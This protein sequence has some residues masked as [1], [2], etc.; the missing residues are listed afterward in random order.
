M[1]DNSVSRSW[2]AVFDNPQDHGYEG[3]PEEVCERLKNEWISAS[4]TRCGAWCYCVSAKGLKHIHMV[5][6]D[7]KPMRFASI[8]KEYAVGMHFEATKGTRKQA[9]D[10]INKVPPFDEKG[11]EILY[12]TTHGE[13]RGRQGKRSDLDDYFDRLEAGETVKDI[14]RDTPRAYVHETVLKK[15]Y[16]DIRS[17]NTPIVRDMRVYWHTGLSGSGKSYERVKLCEEVGEENIFYLTSFNSGAFDNYNGEPYLWIEDYRGE[18]KLQELLRMLDCYKA[19][20]PARYSN[21][22]ALWNEVHITSVLTPREVYSKASLED[23]DRIDQLLRRITSIVYHF[24]ANG[25]EYYQLHFPSN[26][27]RVTM[28]NEVYNSKKFIE[29][30]VPILTDSDYE[31]DGAGDSPEGETSRTDSAVNQSETK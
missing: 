1:N 6:E 17:Q 15:M 22:K 9:E 24:K 18:F 10:Y 29:S 14:L 20:I 4:T 30:F 19:E 13:I 26:S 31:S 16:Y 25:S 8:K 21:A 27:L 12:K 7:S 3:T 11:E 5:L 23:N 28:E 2:F